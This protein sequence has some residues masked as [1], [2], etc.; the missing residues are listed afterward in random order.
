[1]RAGGDFA[2]CG[3]LGLDLDLGAGRV[4]VEDRPG[5]GGVVGLGEIV[6]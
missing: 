2:G 6:E 4:G 5:R 3:F 1:M